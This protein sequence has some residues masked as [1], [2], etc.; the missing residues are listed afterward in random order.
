MQFSKYVIEEQVN[1]YEV[2]VFTCTKLSNLFRK[3]YK[4]KSMSYSLKK[5]DRSSYSNQEKL[6]LTVFVVKMKDEYDLEVE[7]KRENKI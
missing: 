4:I 1:I 3:Y 2:A 5:K 7:K 6:E